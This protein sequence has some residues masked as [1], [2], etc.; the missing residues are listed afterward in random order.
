LTDS[1]EEIIDDMRRKQVNWDGRKHS[2]KLRETGFTQQQ[3]QHTN[4]PKA[5]TAD[6]A[7]L[8]SRFRSLLGLF[9]ERLPTDLFREFSAMNIGPTTSDII[10]QL[11]LYKPEAYKRILSAL[12]GRVRDDLEQAMRLYRKREMEP[13]PLSYR[14]LTF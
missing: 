11:R 9:P 6:L 14:D 7:L 13:A 1:L 5:E 3:K 4:T 2:R 8:A 10:K 12:M